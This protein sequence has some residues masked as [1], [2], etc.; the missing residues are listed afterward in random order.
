MYF[1]ERFR[2]NAKR[3]SI[4]Q[5]RLKKVA[6]MHI[7]DPP[8][9]NKRKVK[10]EFVKKR[11]TKEIIIEAESLSIGYESPLLKGITFQVRG[12]D[13]IAI[14]G[15]NGSGKTTL[16]KTLLGKIPSL[17]GRLEF[18]RPMKLGYFDQSQERLHKEKTIFQEIHDA[19]P[20]MTNFEIRSVA[21]RFLFI[22][23]D[24][25]KQISVLSGGD[26]VRL[27]L[28][29][30]MLERP[31]VLVLDEPTNH[32]D[33]ETREIVEDVLEQ[34]SGPILFVSHDRS[35]INRI[36]T[37]LLVIK[38]KQLR[39]FVGNYQ[40]YKE[41][42]SIEESRKSVERK[43]K[44]QRPKTVPLSKRINQVEVKIDEVTQI[45]KKMKDQAFLPEFYMDHTKMK[46]HMDELE[47]QKKLLYDL[48]Q[49]YLHLLEELEREVHQ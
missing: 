15:P 17:H 22:G 9:Q 36:A 39:E 44:L 42:L 40:S 32:L 1:V 10:L 11:P 4:A 14:I 41:M 38:Q 6:K 49:Q 45:V 16:L 3:A 31:D 7:V 24:L 5:D 35:L 47:K 37:K 33:M 25:D 13:K 18:V 30:L 20:T 48:E 46:E 34:F 12:F 29:L 27:V 21:A 26:K 19:N 28:L 2:Y 8:K 43:K 23:D